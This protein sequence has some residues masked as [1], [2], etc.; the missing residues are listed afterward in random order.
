MLNLLAGPLTSR[1]KSKD[2]RSV[3]KYLGGSYHSLPN[4][5]VSTSVMYLLSTTERISV[6]YMKVKSYSEDKEI[7]R[8]PLRKRISVLHHP[9]IT[10]AHYL[11][12]NVLKR[13][14]KLSINL[15][16]QLLRSKIPLLLS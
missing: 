7:L 11:E 2:I 6:G 14:E 16:F 8:V 10:L 9:I 12:E 15:Y 4:T 5:R 13:H 1:V 3:L